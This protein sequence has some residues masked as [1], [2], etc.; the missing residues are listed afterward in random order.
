MNKEIFNRERIESYF[1]E[2]GGVKDESYI[3]EIFSNDLNK[4]ELKELLSRQFDELPEYEDT[5]IRS[6]LDEILCR[7]HYDINTNYPASQPR[8]SDSVL[9]WFYRVAAVMLLPVLIFTGIHFYKESSHKNEAW[10]EIIAPAWS[11]VKIDLPDGS[12]GWLNS[13]SRIKYRGNFNKD[14]NVILTG[15]AFFDVVSDKRRPFTVSTNDITTKVLGTRFN[16]ASYADDD[17]AEVVLEEGK[18]IFEDN[19]MGKTYTMKP[20]DLVRYNRDK[21]DFLVKE[22]QPQKYISW[23]EGKLVFRNDPLEE[24]AKRLGRWYNVEV[25]IKGKSFEDIRW[26][27]TFVDERLEEV[28]ALMKRSLNVDYTIEDHSLQSDGTFLKRKVILTH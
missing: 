10:V 24:I 26:R 3:N 22:V 4:G 14:R 25:E 9:K 18:L 1:K 2:E 27:A 28:L 12:E 13:G 15:E 17:F 11:R 5:E 6:T 23:T 21:K 8:F 20:G 7:I 19:Q 16:I